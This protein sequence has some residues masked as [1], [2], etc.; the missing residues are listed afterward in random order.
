MKWTEILLESNR[1][2]DIIDM[3]EFR[4]CQRY[5]CRLLSEQQKREILFIVDEDG[6]AGKSTFLKFLFS[7]MKAFFCNGG[8]KSDIMCAWVKRMAEIIVFDMARCNHP[9]YWPYQLMEDMKNGQMQCDKYQ[10]M[11]EVLKSR[12]IVV[13]SNRIGYLGNFTA[14]RVVLVFRK[15]G[16]VVWETFRGQEAIDMAPTDHNSVE[17][18]SN[19]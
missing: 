5:L 12:K 4:V 7:R 6:G 3:E 11:S 10:S 8:K 1:D 18:E 14:D 2:N 19:N 17:A 15:K 13:L 16:S 9:K